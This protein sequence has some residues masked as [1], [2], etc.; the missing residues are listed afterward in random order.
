LGTSWGEC[1][2]NLMGTHKEQ[3][4]KTK[5]PSPPTFSKRKKLDHSWVH[6]EPSHWLHEIS[7]SKAFHHHFWPGLMAGSA[8]WGHSQT[9][10]PNYCDMVGPSLVFSDAFLCVIPLCLHLMII[11]LTQRWWHSLTNEWGI[12]ATINH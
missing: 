2:W 5:I 6:D 8:I 12:M 7:I 9:R 1:F 11:S 3:G 4:R 10:M